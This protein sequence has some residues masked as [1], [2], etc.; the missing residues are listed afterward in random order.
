MTKFAI[1]FSYGRKKSVYYVGHVGNLLQVASDKNRAR[2]FA[3]ADQANTIKKALPTARKP[4]IV[5]IEI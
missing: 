1:K 3:T 2:K 5:E 4:R